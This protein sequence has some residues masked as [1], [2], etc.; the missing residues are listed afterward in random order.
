MPIVQVI[1]SER[2]PGVVQLFVTGADVSAACIA[3]GSQS[4]WWLP[5]ADARRLHRDLGDKLSTEG[6]ES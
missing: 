2:E 6:R 1:V 5:T 4:T 3:G